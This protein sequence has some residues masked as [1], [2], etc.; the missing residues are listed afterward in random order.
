LRRGAAANRL[1]QVGV[2]RDWTMKLPIELLSTDF[3]G[4]LHT[5]FDCPPVPEELEHLIAELQGQGMTWVINTGRD[6]ASLL[7]TL[8]QAQLAIWPDYLV[9]VEREIHCRAN[10]RYVELKEWNQRCRTVHE[11]LFA[12]V[13]PDLPRLVEWIKSRFPATVYEDPYSPFCLIAESGLDAD[14][15]HTFLQEYCSRVPQLTVVRNDV[16]ARLSHSEFNKGSALGA[17][18][19]RLGVAVDRIVAAGDHWNDLPM[20]SRDY[21]RWL[22]APGNA[23]PIV[24]EVVQRQQGYVSERLCGYGVADGLRSLLK[25]LRGE[26]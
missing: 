3:D 13:R 22:I 4:T 14:H 16:Y 5:D 18:A 20:L 8:A 26:R 21:A 6:L 2:L 15:I 12:R 10:Q 23:V 24:K 17:I 25:S 11:Q 7:E 9:T 19:G 1:R